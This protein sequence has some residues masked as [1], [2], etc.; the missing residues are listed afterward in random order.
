MRYADDLVDGKDL[1][2]PRLNRR[3]SDRELDMAASLVKGLETKFKPDDY[4]DTYRKEVLKVIKRKASGKPIEPPDEP[5][6]EPSDD[7]LAALE[8]S[9][10]GGRKRR[11]KA[12]S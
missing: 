10:K 8:A 9:M 12:R 4:E 6:T 11:T 2:L 7:I 3:P 1:D 5:D